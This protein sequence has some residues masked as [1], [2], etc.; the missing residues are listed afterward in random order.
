MPGQHPHIAGRAVSGGHD[1]SGIAGS[2]LEG[3]SLSWR[4]RASTFLATSALAGPL[5]GA[6]AHAETAVA[7]VAGLSVS[8]ID[9]MQL[10]VFVGVTGAALISAIVLIRERARTSAE[11]VELRSRLADINAALRRSEALLNLRDQRVVVWAAENKKPE[12]IGTLPVESGAPEDRAAF[13][14][15]G[16]WLMPRSAAA[17]EHAVA[18]LRE[19]AKPF[20][21]VIESQAGAPL[22]VHGRKSAAHVL[23]RFVSLSETQRSQARLKI[24]NQRLAAD[25][26]TMIGLL[27][28]LN[29]PAW[30]RGEDGGL[31]WVNRAYADAVEAENA[32]AAV[33]EKKEFLGGQARDAIAAQHRTHPV[34]EQSL[35]TVIEGDRRV[36]AV[37]D[38]AGSDGSAGL[39][40]DTSAIEAVR[41][42][43]ERTVRSHADTLDQLNTAVAIFDT[44]EKLR[45]FNQAFQKL[46]GLDAGFL[47]SAPDNALL[48][49]RLRSEGKIAEQPEWRRWKE[50][51]LGAYRAV[52]SQEHWWH[53]PDG[54]TI[55][56]VAN[57]QPK[58]GVTWVFENLTEKMDLESRYQTAVRVQG[59]TLDNLA[60]GV[61]VFGPDGRLRLSNPAFA[62]LWGL[63]GEAAKPSVH[64][65][66]IRDLCDRQAADSPWPGFVAAVTGFDDERRDRHGQTEL[67][68]G[69]VL[70]YA[71]IPL[72]NGQVMMTFVD[73]TDSVHVERALKDKNEALQKS[74]Q[75]KNEFVQHV[76]YELRSPLTNIIGFTELLS[77]PTTGPLTQ[78]QREYVEHVSSSS[79]VLLTI[80]NDI[81]DLAT[82][83]AGIMQLDISEVQ[84]DRTIAAAAELVADRLEEH[85]IRLEVEAASA[86]K[87]FHGDEVRVRQ[88]LYNLLSNA[89]NYAPEASTIRLTC[90]HLA[91]GVEFSV[92]DDGPGMPPDVLDSVFRRFEPRANGGRRRGAGLGLSIVK[93]FVE[94]HGGSVRI[95]T[96]KD[97]GTTVICTFP[98]MPGI[99][100]AAE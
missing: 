44:D 64:V 16:R 59:E 94:L 24:E 39:A 25:H 63:S 43:Y 32:E 99:R 37:T 66:T 86:P 76:S 10:A 95:E 61:A 62:T 36:F 81:L 78:K 92:H 75:L 49:D 29:M 46:W 6:A 31:R 51:L 7:S 30:L 57:P 74:D 84:V 38:F 27:D 48:L 21:L 12:L 80:V 93:S 52:E 71:M 19:K 82:V 23:V 98:D 11:N 69:N 15:F 55:R 14:A 91:D 13:L 42:E 90:R 65:S 83:D 72:P 87:T 41:G 17:L 22:E 68:N 56:V 85:S 88:I 73:V 9:V 33:R 60:E 1:D 54:K 2:A 3:G 20:D 40:C 96:G 35:S 5:A 58:G 77:Q 100:A 4:A 89:A 34:F 45:F 47:H 18:G 50:G 67:N 79:A 26:D 53:L 28:A 70:S 8:A 97:K